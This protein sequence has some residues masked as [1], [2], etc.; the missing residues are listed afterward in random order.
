[1]IRSLAQAVAPKVMAGATEGAA[2]VRIFTTP[3]LE[4]DETLMA[5]LRQIAHVPGVVRPVVALPDLHW[6]PLLETPSSTVV[7]TAETIV[8]VFSSPSPNCGMALLTTPLAEEELTP[9]LVEAFFAR[10]REAVPLRHTQ[11]ALTRTQL[12][13]ILL[14]GAAAVVRQ[15]GLNPDWLSHMEDRG[16]TSTPAQA[17]AAAISH[18]MPDSVLE[19]GRYG[20]CHLGVGGGHFLELQIV[21][22][23][24]D[25][26]VARL[27]GL[28]EGQVVVMLHTGSSALGGHVGR[29]Y[30]RRRKNTR[31]SAAYFFLKRVLFHGA[32][33]G[34]WR[35]LGR[36]LRYYVLPGAFIGI[37][38]ASSEGQRCLLALDMATNYGYANRLAVMAAVQEALRAASG[39]RDMELSLVWDVSHNSIRQEQVDGRAVWVHRHNACRVPL[40]DRLSGSSPFRHGYPVLL[41]GTNRTVSYLCVGGTGSTAS[42]HSVNHGAGAWVRAFAQRG[43]S[44]ALPDAAP[45]QLFHYATSEVEEVPRLSDEGVM[46]ALHVLMTHDIARPVARLRPLATLSEGK[47]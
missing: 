4:P 9:R 42:L 45:T 44:H 40:P 11:P 46:A 37:P 13:D 27:W 20:F 39:R 12:Q 1:M 7:A 17:D 5:R 32:T 28:E 31:R 18:V 6:K 10:F 41:P 3:L 34:D 25:G 8:P 26:E 47:P 24:V 43:L 14:T 21:E 38:A 30:A 36:R 22:E 2:D 33:A 16:A 15:R 23:V 19:Q 35:T 29:L